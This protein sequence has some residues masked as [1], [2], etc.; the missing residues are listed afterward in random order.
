MT[1]TGLISIN[2]FRKNADLSNT[3]LCDK[4]DIIYDL[5]KYYMFIDGICKNRDFYIMVI[6]SYVH[7]YLYMIYMPK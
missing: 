4:N 2:A 1:I 5:I 6:Y 3:I 7:E